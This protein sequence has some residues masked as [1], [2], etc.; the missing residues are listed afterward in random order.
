[1]MALRAY[2]MDGLKVAAIM[3]LSDTTAQL[4]VEKKPLV[5][6]DTGR[7]LRFGTLGFVFTGPVMRRWYFFLDS[8]VPKELPVVP[9]ALRKML[10]DQVIFAP[11]YAFVMSCLVP[12][13]NGE[14]VEEIRRRLRESYFTLLGISCLFWPLAQFI[15]F[16]YIPIDYQAIYVQAVALL[17]NCYVSVTLN[18]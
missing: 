15:N 5:D 3:A 17:W 1:A 9:R 7:T 8:K 16:I 6:W 4:Y 13:V 10:V 12:L 2:L 14:S 18:K 11:P